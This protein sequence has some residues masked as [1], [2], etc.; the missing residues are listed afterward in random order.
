MSLRVRLFH[1][2]FLLTRPMTLG[3]RGIVLDA[4][5][6]VLLV[7]HTYVPGWHLP[8]G[9]IEPGETALD[10]LKREVLEEGNVAVG[11]A[12]KLHGFFFNRSATRRDHVVVYVCEDATTNGPKR[13]DRE[14]AEAGFFPLDALPAGITEGSVRR[15]AEWRTGAAPDPEW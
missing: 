10:C 6:K 15:I 3:V 9:G 13:R 12:I 1:S 5:N 14:I 11:D 7:R 4:H 2:W 8:G